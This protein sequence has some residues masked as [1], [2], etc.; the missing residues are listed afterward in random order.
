MSSAAPKLPSV[1]TR[2]GQAQA[3]ADD[4]VL[5]FLQLCCLHYHRLLSARTLSRAS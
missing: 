4:E 2:L 3:Q 1:G 5:G